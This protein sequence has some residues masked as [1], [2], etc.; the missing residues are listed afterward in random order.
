MPGSS[1]HLIDVLAH[2]LEAEIPPQEPDYFLGHRICWTLLRK[3]KTAIEGDMLKWLGPRYIEK[4]YQLPFLVGY[5]F[6]SLIGDQ[7]TIH[8]NITTSQRLPG[9]DLFHKAAQVY[10]DIYG[11]EN[12][13]VERAQAK[14]GI[15]VFHAMAKMRKVIPD[16]P[17]PASQSHYNGVG[18]SRGILNS[19]N[20][21]GEWDKD[22]DEDYDSDYSD[23]TAGFTERLRNT[24]RGGGSPRLQGQELMDAYAG[25]W[26]VAARGARQGR[27]IDGLVREVEEQM[28][29]VLGQL[30][31][32]GHGGARGTLGGRGGSAGPEGL[33]DL[34]ELTGLLE[35]MGGLE[36]LEGL[37]GGRG[38]RQNMNGCRQ[39]MCR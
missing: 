8:G 14:N 1:V 27:G 4:V 31:R 9:T 13:E 28:G 20:M 19:A 18:A 36:G 2:A 24:T 12:G 5:V 39:L 29:R 26:Q 11:G 35:A 15:D 33:G 38:G 22:Y 34:G 21:D 30:G 37:G 6:R 7:G 17:H 16:D 23:G 3:L 32:R 10:L 25:M